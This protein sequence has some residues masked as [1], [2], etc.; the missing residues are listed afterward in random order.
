M[1]PSFALRA[2]AERDLREIADYSLTTHGK[3]AM[4]VERKL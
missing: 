1:K 4:D 3:K 2:A